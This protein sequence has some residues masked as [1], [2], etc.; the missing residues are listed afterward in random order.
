MA[1]DVLVIGGGNAGLCAA[2]T[3]REAGRK[4]LLLEGAPAWRR[5]GNSRHTRDIRYMHDVVGP[6]VTGTYLEDEFWDDLWRVTG[7]ETT[8]SLA[9]QTIRLSCDLVEW[10][11]AHGVEWQ[12]PLRGTLHLSRTNVFMLGGGAGLATRGQQSAH[13]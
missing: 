3:A 1:I 5:G 8:E 9:R 13:A 2:I 12:P 10:T 6:Y 11:Q 4:V 7:G